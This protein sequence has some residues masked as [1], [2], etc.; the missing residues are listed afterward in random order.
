ML[1][2][3]LPLLGFLALL[4]LL[5]FG[6]WWN[7]QHEINEVPSPLI[8]K[9]A[10]EFSLPQLEKSEKLITR[11]ALLGQPYLLNV[12]AS[13]C[14]ACQEEHP[15]LMAQAKNFGV[16]IIGYNYKDEPEN[17]KQWLTQFGN[18]YEIILVDSNGRTAID[19]GIYGAP[20][21][22]LIDSQGIIRYKRIGPF[23]PDII[24]HELKPK[25]EA[26]KGSSP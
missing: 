17:A 4:A 12:F 11:Q 16:K 10:P 26:I 1:G 9:P 20:E 18:P 5:G 15:V 8:G 6:I 13:W 25:I 24:E 7:R 22:F 14:F 3:L 19:F 21:S 2:R 23:T